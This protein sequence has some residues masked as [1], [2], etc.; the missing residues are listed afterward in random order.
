MSMNYCEDCKILNPLNRCVICGKNHLRE[1]EDNDFVYLNK[2]SYVQ[3]C[4]IENSFID[5]K[6]KYATLPVGE[7]ARSYLGLALEFLKVFVDFKN[8]DL[9]DSIVNSLL[10]KSADELKQP[11]IDNVHLLNMPAKQEKKLQ[12]KLK[13]IAP[14]DLAKDIIINST[15]VTDGGLTYLGQEHDFDE[16]TY[17]GHLFYFYSGNLVAT[18]NSKTYTIISIR[19]EK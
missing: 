2:M 9:A 10:I 7:G 19:K 15:K 3:F 4:E 16:E 12:R 1:P 18:V 17:D 14:I 5:N 8:L 6:I 13:V 11:F